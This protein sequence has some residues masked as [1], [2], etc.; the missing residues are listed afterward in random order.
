MTATFH[1]H[2]MDDLVDSDEVVERMY[3]YG[4]A[5][6][7][8][9]KRLAPKDSGRGAESIH[10]EIVH[11]HGHRRVRVSWDKDHFYMMFAELGTVNEHPRPF[12]RPAASRYA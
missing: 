12:L 2:V 4:E 1:Q 5:I 9:A 8:E 3:A 7:E 11:G 6:A 10:P